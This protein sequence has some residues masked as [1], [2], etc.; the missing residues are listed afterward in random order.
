VRL[1]AHDAAGNVASVVDTPVS[2]FSVMSSDTNKP[3]AV[4]TSPVDGMTVGAGLVDIA[5]TS[6]D[7]ESVVARVRVRIH[8]IGVSP[9]QYWN[10]AE[11]TTTTSYPDALLE[12]SGAWVLPG[13]DVSQPASYRIRL[14]AYDANGNVASV[15]DNP[16][17][18]FTSE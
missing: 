16:L 18:D 8:R 15:R 14:I 10:G 3:A 9:T 11:W 6:N 5:G 17:V 13:V 7:N 2:D 4:V 12:D 1:I